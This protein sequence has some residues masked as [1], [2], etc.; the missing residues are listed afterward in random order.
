MLK[1]LRFS[2]MEL[3]SLKVLTQAGG[4]LGEELSKEFADTCE[5]KG[6]DFVVMY[7]QT[8]ATARMSYL[9]SKF[10]KCKA[11]SIGIAIPGGEFYLEDD[12][13]K[14]I[15]T[16]ETIGELIYKGDNVTMGY[17]LSCYD[18]D[19]GDDNNGI[20]KTGDLAKRDSDGFYYIVGRKKRFVKLFGN[21]VNLDEFEQMVKSAGYD[22]ACA[23]EDDELKVFVTTKEDHEKIKSFINEKTGI[24]SVGYKIIYIEKIPRNESGKI[25]YSLLS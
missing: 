3:P 11:G 5:S 16:N 6:L 14:V 17:A 2:R 4:K 12:T 10:A 7:G 18:L 22:C 8:E 1:K 9:P 21:R 24:N 19:K 25:L 13:G 15:E 20:L 23:G